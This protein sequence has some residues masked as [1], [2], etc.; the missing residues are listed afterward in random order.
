VRWSRGQP[1]ALWPVAWLT[2]FK[3]GHII[4]P[5][6]RAKLENCGDCPDR[7]TTVN[8]YPISSISKQRFKSIGAWS[9]I[10]HETLILNGSFR[11]FNILK[12]VHVMIKFLHQHLLENT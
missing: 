12:K 8:V 4:M 11:V 2:V 5:G 1:T 7:K 9:L 6:L 10:L 3:R